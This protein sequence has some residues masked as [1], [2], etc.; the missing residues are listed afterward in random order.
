MLTLMDS[1]QNTR[2]ACADNIDLRWTRMIDGVLFRDSHADV[3][4]IVVNKR[5]D[6]EKGQYQ[7]AVV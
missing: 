1:G 2:Y 5:H 6:N 4:R 3:V 7:E